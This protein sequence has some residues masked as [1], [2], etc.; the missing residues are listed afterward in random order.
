MPRHDVIVVGA[1]HAGIEAAL[2]CAR[3]GRSTLLLTQN[4][5][6]IGAMSCN[7]S[8]GGVAKGQIV[9]ELDALGGQMALAT[10]Q[11]GLHYKTLNSS[12]GHAVRSPRAQCDKKLYH[13]A[14]KQA[15]EEQPGL[16]CRQDE[17]AGLWI[18]NG[19]L[20]G[21]ISK[22]G[23]R[24]EARRVILTTGT[25]LNGL[26]HIGLQSFPSGRAGDQPAVSLSASL[27][28]LGFSV[29][30]MK[31]GTPP[32]LDGRSIDYSRCERQPSDV[33][34]KPHPRQPRPVA[35]IFGRHPVDRAALLPFGRGQGRQVPAEGAPSS[36]SRAGRLSNA[37]SLRQRTLHE[38]ARGRAAR[39]GSQRARP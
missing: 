3:M 36:L 5:D 13:L 21:L 37:G 18:E 17:A 23:T 24:Y 4:L 30:R 35:I 1:G 16:E 22:R 33:P 28:E 29:G 25:F 34:A 2:A 20:A 31:T 6:T 8:I 11:A 14:M 12:K 26:A 27:R 9:R 38:P 39:D 7:P 32:R 10:D 15:V 19:R